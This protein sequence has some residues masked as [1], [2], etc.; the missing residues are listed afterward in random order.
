MISEVSSNPS[1]LEFSVWNLEFLVKMRQTYSRPSYRHHM[2]CW[3]EPGWWATVVW[4]F[5]EVC[6]AGGRVSLIVV[7]QQ[8]LATPT[9][10]SVN[11]GCLMDVLDGKP[12]GW[13]MREEPWK[14]QWFK[15]E[16]CAEQVPKCAYPPRLWTR[17]PLEKH[18]FLTPRER[19]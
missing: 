5:P 1:V 6:L 14:T 17:A 9:G 10:N 2:A 3:L 15:G 4:A 19:L 8:A 7:L 18:V 11:T 13:R 16:G 12:T